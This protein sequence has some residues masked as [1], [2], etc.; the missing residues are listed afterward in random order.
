MLPGG[1]SGAFYQNYDIEM[2]P[3]LS[4]P[5]WTR[6]ATIPAAAAGVPMTY[7]DFFVPAPSRFFRVRGNLWE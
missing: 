2:T 7:Q 6:T 5:N 3:S 1:S 4:T